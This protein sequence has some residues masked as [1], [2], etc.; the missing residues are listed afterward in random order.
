MQTPSVITTIWGANT[1]PKAAG[2]SEAVLQLS[3]GTAVTAFH[4]SPRVP[5]NGKIPLFF[6]DKLK[7][8]TA[9]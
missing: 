1:V 7:L 3:L 6:P 5:W 2:D 8:A 4:I 9:E